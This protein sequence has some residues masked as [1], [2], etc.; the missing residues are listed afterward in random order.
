MVGPNTSLLGGIIA[1]VVLLVVNAL[2]SKLRMHLPQML[3][4]VEGSPTLLVLHGKKPA[5]HMRRESIYEES[6]LAALREH[7]L[8]EISQVEM[9][10]LE[11]DGSI[12]V[13]PIGKTTTLTKKS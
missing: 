2:V 3:R 9:A 6:L 13:V 1:A 10:G 12:S 8:A 4:L 11:I 7:G 5:D